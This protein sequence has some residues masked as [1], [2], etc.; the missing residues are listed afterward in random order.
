MP[1]C[2]EGWEEEKKVPWEFPGGPVVRTQCFHRCGLGSIPSGELR[3]LKLRGAAK[4]KE[5]SK[6]FL[7]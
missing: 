2:E 4:K 6:T 5:K 3:S 1:A 7:N